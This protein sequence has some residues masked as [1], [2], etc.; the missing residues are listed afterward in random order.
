MRAVFTKAWSEV[1]RRRLQSAVIVVMVALASGT[2]TLGL[3]LLLESRSPY[4]HAF[5]AQNGANLK[6]FYDARKVT[7]GQLAS[8]PAT[9]GASSFAG[10]WPDVYVTL[11]HR[12]SSHGQSRHPLDLVGRDSPQGPAEVLRMTSG[13]WVQAP[14]EVVVNR[15]FA[16]SNRVNLGDH[17]VSLHT[18]DKPALTVVGEAV[19][20]SQTSAGSNISV[21]SISRAQRAWVLPSQ[22]ADLAGGSGL[23]YEM[24]YR[25]GPPPARSSFATTWGGCG[26]ACLREPSADPPATWRCATPTTSATSSCSSCC[27]PSAVSPWPPASPS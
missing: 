3:N 18:A 15:A 10:P 19:D 14:G 20:I 7:P 17:L 5:E 2:I 6:V 27:L 8:S 22:V 23:G 26:A 21:Q 12:E 13:R 4:D 16:E 9:I 25:S 1:R 24:A 11:L